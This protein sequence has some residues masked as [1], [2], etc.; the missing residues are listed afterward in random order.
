LYA[1]MPI[2]K[3]SLPRL[4]NALK[5]LRAL[6]SGLE[7]GFSPA[8]LAQEVLDLLA[9]A[10]GVKPV[11]LLGR[12]FDDPAWVAGA[13]MVADEMKLR[14]IQGPFWDAPEAM[15]GL[16]DW[17]VALVRADL[18]PFRAFYVARTAAVAEKLTAACETGFPTAAEEAALLGYPPCCVAAHQAR[19]RT[20]HEAMLSILARQA[21]DDPDAQA[22]LMASGDPLL[23]ETEAEQ[24]AFLGGMQVTPGPF[25]SVNLCE[26]CAADRDSPGAK[27]SQQYAALA[28]EIDPDFAR[29]F[30]AAQG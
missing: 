7:P 6:E 2:A 24:A 15:E 26:S 28:V 18:A 16:P 8:E 10:A 20:F 13:V 9:V 17:Y 11:C 12:G 21:G 30:A 22:K 29:A 1:I 19:N 4:R 25:T 3:T 14:V 23:P 5:K 27:M